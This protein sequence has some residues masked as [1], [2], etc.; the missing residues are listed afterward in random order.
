MLKRLMISLSLLLMIGGSVEL[1]TKDYNKHYAQFAA[2][3]NIN[4][5]QLGPFLKRGPLQF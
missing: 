4:V 2:G 5:D 1:F 3:L